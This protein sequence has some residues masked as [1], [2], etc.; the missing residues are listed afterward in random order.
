MIIDSFIQSHA[1]VGGAMKLWVLAGPESVGF[2]KK[3]VTL[4]LFSCSLAFVGACIGS[5]DSKGAESNNQAEFVGTWNGIC[6]D[7]RPFVIVRLRAEKGQIVGTVSIGNMH[8]NVDGGCEEVVDD[9]TPEHAQQIHDAKIEGSTLSF[10]W[11]TKAG[12]QFEMKLVG[13]KEAELKFLG[14]PAE[15]NPWKLI[16]E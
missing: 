7:Q 9:P 3:T 13:N 15:N 5:A 8:G 12:R 4:A 16:R 1:S 11:G 2:S 6:G 14:T 10:G